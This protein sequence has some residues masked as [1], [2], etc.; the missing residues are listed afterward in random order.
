MVQADLTPV[1]AVKDLSKV[2]GAGTAHAV[3]ALRGLTFT[4]PRGAFAAVM[5]QSGSGKSTLLNLIGCLDRATGGTYRL[6]G[7]DVSS[8]SR[9]KLAHVR[10]RT[11]GFVFQ[12][13]HL[14]PRLTTQANCE[15][16]L[17]YL[18]GVPRRERRRRAAEALARVSLSDK[19][20]RFP[21][22]LS[23]GQ[24]QRVAI[25]RALVNRPA[26]LLADEPTGN[27]DARTGLEI[28]VLLQELHAEG[29]TLILVTHNPELSAHAQLVLSLEDGLLAQAE[30]RAAPRQA[31]ETLAAYLAAHAGARDG[32]G[33]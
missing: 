15:L 24:Q 27:L 20:D 17:Q 11:L 28:L 31:R 19:L 6:D 25:A 2:Y 7:Q 13:F 10:A 4:V 30:E 16:P 8:F 23:G 12:S 33:G 3:P 22:E 5:G 29:M 32:K 1:V 21:T 14:L 9:R 18:G 26:L